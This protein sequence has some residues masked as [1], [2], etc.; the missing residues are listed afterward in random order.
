MFDNPF[1][2][3]LRLSLLLGSLSLGSCSSKEGAGPTATYAGKVQV[4]DE[5][6][7]LLS[8]FGGVQVR[9]ADKPAVQTLTAAD[10]SFS[11]PQV[12]AGKHR[13]LLRHAVKGDKTFDFSLEPGGNVSL[14][15]NFMQQ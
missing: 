2:A 15:H 9:L 7:T 1:P 5:F 3:L 12:P 8:D 14:S 13:L 4:Y 6:G 11:L 10:G